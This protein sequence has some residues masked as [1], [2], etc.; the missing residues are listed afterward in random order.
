MET[1]KFNDL[2]HPDTV[3]IED[4]IPGNNIEVRTLN[5][6]GSYTTGR[7]HRYNI[8]SEPYFIEYHQ[9]VMSFIKVMPLSASGEIAGQEI[10]RSLADMGIVPYGSHSKTG[11]NTRYT[12]VPMGQPD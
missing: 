4:L 9:H 6:D 11:Y 5:D 12:T 3:K 10:E 7:G 2:P 8:V 1:V